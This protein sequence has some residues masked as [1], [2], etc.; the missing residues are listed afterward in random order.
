MPRCK[1]LLE[2]ILWKEMYKERWELLL[3]CEERQL[4]TAIRQYDIA[5]TKLKLDMV[6]KLFV[7]EVP[8][9]EE[10]RP[11]VMKDDKIFVFSHSDNREYVGFVQL[12]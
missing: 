12:I 3:H 6:R 8:G 4:E 7:L 9:L 2:E 5:D 1:E 10:N 11:S